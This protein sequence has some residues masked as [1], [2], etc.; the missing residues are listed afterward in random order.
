MNLRF[1]ISSKKSYA[2]RCWLGLFLLSALLFSGCKQL[3]GDGVAH[4]DGLRR[5]DLALPAREVRS[6]Q[7]PSTAKKSPD[8]VFMSDE[9]Q[10]VYH[11][12]D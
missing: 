2:G 5:D 9:A 11:D 6:H 12:L 1:H 3:G 4:D 7:Y 10:R 8:D